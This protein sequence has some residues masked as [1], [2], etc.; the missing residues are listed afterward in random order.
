M[1][2][3]VRY[4]GFF[5]DMTKPNRKL[6]RKLGI[7]KQKQ[8]ERVGS[9]FFLCAIWI[10]CIWFLWLYRLFHGNSNFLHHCQRSLLLLRDDDDGY[11][12]KVRCNAPFPLSNRDDKCVR[13]HEKDGFRSENF[14]SRKVIRGGWLPGANS[15]MK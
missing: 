5:H 6:L 4:L 2:A 3:Q 1:R 8:K 13:M 10:G 9:L 7:D 11:F 12:Q 15:F 14:E